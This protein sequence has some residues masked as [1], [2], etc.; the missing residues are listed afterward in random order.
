L[1]R[2]W[3][4][5]LRLLLIAGLLAPA[6][7][8]LAG[9]A[10]R[11]LLRHETVALTHWPSWWVLCAGTAAA[12]ASMGGVSLLGRLSPALEQALRQSATRV[13]LEALSVAGYPVMLVVVTTAAFGEEMLFRGGLQPVIGLWPAAI[14]FGLSHGGWRRE[15]WAYVLAAAYS[16]LVFGLTYQL[17]GDIWAPVTAHALHNAAATLLMGKKVDVTWA[18]WYPRIRVIPE[19]SP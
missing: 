15:M 17:V 1:K 3:W 9:M 13:G 18:G 6:T 2:P 11:L 12:G 8:A 5:R 19:D 14:L 16:G 10:L 7:M 4:Q